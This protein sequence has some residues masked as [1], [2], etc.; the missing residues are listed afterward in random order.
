M[1]DHVQSPTGGRRP[2][3]SGIDLVHSA[4]GGDIGH[5][6]VRERRRPHPPRLPDEAT[7]LP[8]EQDRSVSHGAVPQQRT[9]ITRC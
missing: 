3:N 5:S 6:R 1:D 8:T 2:R 4:D 9:T 7:E